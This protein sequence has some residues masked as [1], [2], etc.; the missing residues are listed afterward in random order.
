MIIKEFYIQ[1]EDGINLIRTFS[2]EDFK[3]QKVGTLEIYEE[4]IDVEN[5]VFDYIETAEKV[6]P[7]ERSEELIEDGE[8]ELSG[9]ELAT[10]L[11]EVL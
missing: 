1:R 11:E 2:D 4:A 9:E 10:M 5:S 6:E 8:Q 3:I 7:V